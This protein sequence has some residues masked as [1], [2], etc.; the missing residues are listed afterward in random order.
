MPPPL[1]TARAPCCCHRLKRAGLDYWPAVCVDVHPS[2]DAFYAHWQ[3]Q[4]GPKQLVGYTKFASQ[5]YASEGL[6]SGGGS[7][8]TWLM[9]GAET[10]GLPDEAHGAATALVKIPM[11]ETYVRSLNLATSVGAWWQRVCA[12][13]PGAGAATGP[14]ARLLPQPT[15]CLPCASRRRHPPCHTGIGVMEVLRQKDGAVLPEDRAA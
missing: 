6:Y 7:G 4:P 3:A 12:G 13:R 9:F 2:W 5:H 8:A 10:T 15:C 11:S 14:A 1:T